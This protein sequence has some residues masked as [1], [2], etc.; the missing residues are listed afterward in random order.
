M[1]TE[2]TKVLNCYIE[3]E[4]NNRTVLKVTPVLYVIL[5][6]SQF[7]LPKSW[8]WDLWSVKDQD[9]CMSPNYKVLSKI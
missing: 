6:L 9:S 5:W 2:E 3:S 1:V 7:N 8:T 4:W